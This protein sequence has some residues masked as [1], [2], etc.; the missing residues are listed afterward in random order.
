[1]AFLCMLRFNLHSRF[2]ASIAIAVLTMQRCACSSTSNPRSVSRRFR[3][4]STWVMFGIGVQQYAATN[5]A[6]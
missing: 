1:V 6:A 4:D 2:A 3:V 5:C